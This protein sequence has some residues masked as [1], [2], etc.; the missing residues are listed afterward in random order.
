MFT[1]TA[2][3]LTVSLTYSLGPITALLRLLRETSCFAVTPQRDQG[4]EL[5][6]VT[7]QRDQGSEL[8]AVTPQ[9]DQGSELVAVTLQRDQGSE[10]VAVTLQRDQGSELGAV[11]STT[12]TDVFW[13]LWEMRR[14]FDTQ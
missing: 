5:V 1:G 14:G 4:S 12:V 6:A 11:G 7:P 10:L 13:K 3:I 9:R 8:V 2:E